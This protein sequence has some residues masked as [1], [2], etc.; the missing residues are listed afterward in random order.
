MKSFKLLGWFS[1]FAIILLLTSCGGSNGVNNAPA[2]TVSGVAAAGG[3]LIGSV[4]LED[5][6]NP[7][8]VISLPIAADGSFSFNVNGLTAPFLLKAIGTVGG[9]NYTLYSF[10]AGSGIANV[11]PLSNLAV[12][13]ANGGDLTSLYASPNPTEML[14]IKNTL[15]TNIAQIQE[16]L[17]PTLSHFGATTVNFISDPYVANHSGLDLF[18]DLVSISVS[19]G[20][21]TIVDNTTNNTVSSSLSSFL[22]DTINIAASVNSSVCILPIA[23]SVSANGTVN[24]TAIVVGSVNQQVTWSVVETNGGTITS[25]GVYT[26]PTNAGTYHVTATSVEDATKSATTI[27]TV[28]QPHPIIS[29]LAGSATQGNPSDGTGAGAVF[30][31]GGSV[32][33]DGLGNVFVSDSGYLRKVTPAGVVTTL[34]LTDST[35]GTPITYPGIGPIALDSAGNIYAVA[36]FIIEKITPAGV[37]S[38]IAGSGSQGTADGVGSKASFGGVAGIALDSTGNIYVA[39]YGVN[40][41]RIITSAG[42]VSTFAGSGATGN[43]NGAGATAT[44]NLG[45]YG[46]SG[47]I[48]DNSGNV[49]VVEW[50]NE[51]VRKITPNGVVSTLAGGPG[52]SGFTDGAGSVAS[53][54]NPFAITVDNSSNVYVADGTESIRK[55]NP[56]GMVSTVVN[57]GGVQGPLGSI[58]IDSSGNLY[59]STWGS[60][61]EIIKISFQ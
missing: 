12:V 25:T 24:F 21:V 10:A 58:A 47:I 42:L 9:N 48:V 8:Q 3:P 61:A 29:V 36:G 52:R 50:L 46:N 39:D 20:T 32:A 6:S 11:N 53:F 55:I 22:T 15:A 57:P 16:V 2:Q 27:V 14:A 51:D 30:W 43:A 33:V 31:G 5:S 56:F 40:K 13:E 4:Y 35:T 54:A 26:A 23:P 59:A 18:M 45:G 44:F 37:V 60:S 7:S 19:N 49:Y 41:I 17:Q 1:V 28:N 34:A 38:T